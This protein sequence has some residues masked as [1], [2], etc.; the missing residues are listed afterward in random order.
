MPQSQCFEHLDVCRRCRMVPP[1]KCWICITAMP[2]PPCFF[3]KVGQQP[4]QVGNFRKIGWTK[5]W[6]KFWQDFQHSPQDFAIFF[7]FGNFP[8]SSML[9]H[10]LKHLLHNLLANWKWIFTFKIVQHRI[11]GCLITMK[12]N[13][14]WK[15]KFCFLKYEIFGRWQFLPNFMINANFFCLHL[16]PQRVPPVICLPAPCITY[17]KYKIQNTKYKTAKTWS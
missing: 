6:T 5:S 15:L 7:N 16:P 4:T 1:K 9:V 8:A 10:H 14:H 12:M 11:L 17:T 13:R 3:T 2:Q